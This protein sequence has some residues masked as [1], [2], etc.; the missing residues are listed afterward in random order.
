MPCNVQLN[1]LSAFL[2]IYFPAKCRVQRDFFDGNLF[3]CISWDTLVIKAYDRTC[4]CTVR[5]FSSQVDII[6]GFGS[7][8]SRGAFSGVVTGCLSSIST[9]T[10]PLF[11]PLFYLSCANLF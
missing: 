7:V 6:V 5:G 2:N 10:T 1:G 8:K 9:S 3:S 11:C 4:V